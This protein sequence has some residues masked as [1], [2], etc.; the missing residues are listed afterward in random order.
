ME[1]SVNTHIDNYRLNRNN[2]EPVQNQKNTMASNKS[3]QNKN[4]DSYYVN[5]IFKLD[6]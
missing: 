6:K 2:F 3:Y 1:R 5:N 4:F